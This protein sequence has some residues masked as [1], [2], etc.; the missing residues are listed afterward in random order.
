MAL[1]E[2]RVPESTRKKMLGDF[3]TP[4]VAQALEEHYARRAHHESESTESEKKIRTALE[5]ARRKRVR[6]QRVGALSFV[7]F[8][9]LLVWHAVDHSVP[10]F[11]SSI[12][13]FFAALIAIF[14]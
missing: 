7:P 6:A 1:V 2:E 8:V 9:G 4:D 11:W 14:P 12:V 5:N 13:A 3:L 10:L